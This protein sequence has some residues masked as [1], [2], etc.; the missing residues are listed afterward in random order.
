V[1][2]FRTVPAHCPLC[3]KQPRQEHAR[4]RDF[5]Y[6]TTGDTEWTFRRCVTCDVLSLSPRPADGET[7]LIYPSNYYA[8]DFSQTRSV[9]Y[10]VK[11]ALD[12]RAAR[13][14][15]AAAAVGGD[16][17]DVGCGDGRLLQI[18]HAGGVP[19]SS[20]FGVELDARAVEAA[21]ARGFQVHH[22]AFEGA[23]FPARTFRLVV[24]QQVIEHAPD[25]RAMIERIRELLLPGGAVVLETPNTASWDHFLFARRY[26]GGYHFPRHFHLFSRRSLTALLREVGLEVTAVASLASPSF[27]VQSLHHLGADRGF[28]QAWKNLFR[29]HP[30]RLVP[31]AAFSVL[32]ALGKLARMTSNMRVIAVRK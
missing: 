24:L 25:P 7:P 1:K 15:L 18:L 26:W 29:P 13:L 19:A 16:I 4:G 32:D 30:P 12:R 5:E 10:A 9:G 8:Y 31:L 21:R 2:D 17:L 6:G 20:L 22:G 27:W 11:A 23:A 3:G 28:P 14:Y